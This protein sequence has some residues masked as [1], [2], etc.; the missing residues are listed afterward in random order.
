MFQERWKEDEK[1]SQW[2]D[3]D[4]KSRSKVACKNCKKSIDL[5]CMGE[6]ALKSLA[7]VSC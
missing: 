6:S 2:I 4:C 7:K 3:S 5:A 1:Y